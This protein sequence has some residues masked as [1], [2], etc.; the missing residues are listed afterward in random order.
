MITLD[1]IAAAIRVSPV[2]AFASIV[3]TR[4]IPQDNYGTI[5]VAQKKK[6][7]KYALKL[8]ASQNYAIP[9]PPLS[10]LQTR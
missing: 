5:L 2:I 7:K 9:P 8:A 10:I 6:K 1:T 4:S 3:L